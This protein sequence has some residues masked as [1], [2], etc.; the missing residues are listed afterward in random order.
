MFDN[1]F[2]KFFFGFLAL[3]GLGLVGV[4]VSEAYSSSGGSVKDLIANFFR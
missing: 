3:V 4:V 1:D 2:L